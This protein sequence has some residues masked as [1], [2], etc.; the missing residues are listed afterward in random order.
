[1]LRIWISAA[2]L[3]AVAW[4]SGGCGDIRADRHAQQAEQLLAAGNL[5]EALIELLSALKT[6][7]DNADYAQRIADLLVLKGE[8]ARARFYYGEAYR[9]DRANYEAAIR[10]ATLE[11]AAA[12]DEADALI[13]EVVAN[14]PDSAWGPIGESERALYAH[15][16]GAALEHAERAVAVEPSNADAHWQVTRARV[17]AIH[18]AA[19]SGQRVP[20]AMFEDA[21]AALDQFGELDHER[22][23]RVLEERARIFTAWPGHAD[24]AR[25]ALHTASDRLG[26]LGLLASEF[27][28]L[29][30]ALDY[31]RANRDSEL[32][33]WAL[34][35]KLE[36]I[37]GAW[38]T[39]EQLAAL[40]ERE[41][42]GPSL[43]HERMIEMFPDAIEP[44]LI[45]AR[46]IRD[47]RGMRRAIRYL[48]SAIREGVHAA[49]LL[50]EI[51]RNQSLLG[52]DDASR[53]TIAKLESRFPDSRE[54]VVM[55]AWGWLESGRPDTAIAVLREHAWT[56][57]DI[58]AQQ[59]LV[60]AT[61]RAGNTAGA[62]AALERL[63]ELL[64]EPDLLT[65]RTYARALYDDGQL[66][67]ARDAYRELRGK[68][69]LTPDERAFYAI[70]LFE[71]GAHSVGRRMLET[72]VDAA[73]PTRAAVL[74]LHTIEGARERNRDRLR[75]GFRKLLAEAPDDIAVLS[76]WARLEMTAGTP[77]NALPA[78]AR[79]VENR[80]REGRNPAGALS[81]QAELEEAAGDVEA[82]RA[83]ALAALDAAPA[84]PHALQFAQKLYAT[85]ADAEAG[86]MALTQGIEN[87][88]QPAQRHALLGRLYYRAGNT[89]M[90]RW[91]YEQALSG[92]L[93]LPILKNDLAFLLAS[94][95]RDLKR[96]RVLALQAR[97]ALP[98][99]SGVADT[100]G[101]VMLQLG[102]NEAAAEQFRAGLEVAT[103]NGQPRAELQYHLGLALSRLDRMS[104]AEQAFA[105]ALDLGESFPDEAKARR[106]LATLRGEI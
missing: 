60:D 12:P 11:L 103:A 23:W 88:E 51:A 57:D 44:R 7:P 16:L 76:A 86:I 29:E 67:A 30:R 93:E 79:S 96:A 80:R 52:K 49:P 5:D 27:N 50:A 69:S 39:W 53:A 25:E 33:E 28:V 92:G 18:E 54:A 73:R 70:C 85:K 20:D 42:R 3:I 58:P 47:K 35:R 83:S 77:A 19:Q 98:H 89:V 21:L 82:A 46:F 8:L 24:E 101:F 26:E 41:Q 22:S 100:L 2:L 81:L 71:T 13:E 45:R 61:R 74:G 37:P 38:S 68:V 34:E 56:A 14:G 91:S 48:E 64:P 43:V 106:E 97:E 40:Y 72:G 32:E 63:L 62:V 95:K 9:I 17:A 66:Y 78:V 75:E 6:A 31:A 105:A 99:E 102:E 104:E 36:R 90:A 65:Q 87:E 15:D 84:A 4:T 55:A 1:M 94:Q 10:L 59:V